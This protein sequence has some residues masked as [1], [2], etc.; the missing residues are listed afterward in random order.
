MTEAEKYEK[1][2]L[3]EKQKNQVIEEAIVDNMLAEQLNVMGKQ[4]HNKAQDLIGCF[5]KGIPIDDSCLEELQ[6]MLIEIKD[7][8][9]KET[10]R[11][12]KSFEL[13]PLR[14]STGWKVAYNMFSEYDPDTD[15][16]E[17]TYESC[18]D[19]LPVSNN[20]LFVDLG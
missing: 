15:G 16:S 18:E 1:I 13:Q 3:W 6:E 5:K 10:A 12:I 9:S 19:L 14:I 8:A 7:A 11:T 4:F 2:M 17:Y 20:N